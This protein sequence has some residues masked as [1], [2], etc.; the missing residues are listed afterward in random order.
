MDTMKTNT[1]P[2]LSLRER[3]FNKEIFNVGDL[4]ESNQVEFKIISRGTNYL[5][6]EDT[7]GNKT[8]KWIQD[9]TPMIQETYTLED[10]LRV[11]EIIASALGVKVKSNSPQDTINAALKASA[12]NYG[13]SA[14]ADAVQN[15]LKTVNTVGINYDKKLAPNK[16]KNVYT[17]LRLGQSDNDADDRPGGKSDADSDDIQSTES[18]F[19]TTKHDTN[20]AHTRVGNGLEGDANKDHLRRMKTKKMTEETE[21]KDCGESPCACVD[22]SDEAID[23]MIKHIDHFDDIVDLYDDDELHIVDT[24]GKHHSHLKEELITEVLTRLERIK[25]RVRFAQTASKRSRK[26]QIALHTRST[27]KKINHR[28]RIL[29][30]KILKLKLAKKPLADLSF[31]EKER[32]ERIIAKKKT[33]LS[34]MALKLSPRIRAIENT[35]LHPINKE[36]SQ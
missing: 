34:R 26:L 1:S 18:D 36:S 6:L 19:D 17:M 14:Y 30:V 31:Q 13:K 2:E 4:V 8:K 10:Q 32:L 15:M 3:Y 7:Y 12:C 35:R 27:P 5:F 9:V 24:E 33:L 16:S 21:C 22:D 23:K 11:A 28:A 20:G 25:A 29:A